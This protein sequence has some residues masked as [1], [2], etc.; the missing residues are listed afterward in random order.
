MKRR[1]LRRTEVID[2]LI[3]PLYR[4]IAGAAAWV[5]VILAL[6]LAGQ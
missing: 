4:L 6:M 1:P 5:A 3:T 2:R